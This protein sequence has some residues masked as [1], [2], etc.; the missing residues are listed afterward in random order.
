MYAFITIILTGM[1][2]LL[3]ALNSQASSKLY[4]QIILLTNISIIVVIIKIF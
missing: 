3:N 4:V 1:Q 2:E